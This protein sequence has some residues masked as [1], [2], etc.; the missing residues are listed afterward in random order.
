MA[1][2]PDPLSRLT[3]EQLCLRWRCSYLPLQH[4][5]DCTAHAELVLQRQLYLDEL[6]QRDPD[7]LALA[8]RGR[9]RRQR[10]EPLLPHRG[11]G[12][13][14]DRAWTRPAGW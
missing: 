6:E 12:P 14:D 3:V 7:V 8:G 5:V 1:R 13:V 10:P 2:E 11:Q 4:T 9:P